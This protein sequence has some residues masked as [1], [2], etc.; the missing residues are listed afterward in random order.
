MNRAEIVEKYRKY[1]YGVSTYYNE[2][3]PF[4][5]GEGKWLQDADGR[6]YLDFFGGIVTVALGHCEPR[7]VAAL[8]KQWQ[9]EKKLVEAVRELRTRLEAHAAADGKALLKEFTLI[10]G[11]VRNFDHG[12][13]PR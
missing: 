10:F 5:R 4:V 3:L 6:R 13:A 7:V 2:P 9:Q 8:E 11:T 12:L 1:L